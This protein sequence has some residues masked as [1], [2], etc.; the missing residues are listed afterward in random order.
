MII[1]YYLPGQSHLFDYPQVFESND[2][3]EIENAL[4]IAAREGYEVV[5]VYEKEF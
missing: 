3:E 4:D 1:E 2:P 5:A